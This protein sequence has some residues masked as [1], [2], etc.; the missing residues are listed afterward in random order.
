[1]ALLT[2]QK[3]NE[4]PKGAIDLTPLLW[5]DF[6]AAGYRTLFVEDAYIS[7]QV[8]N[9][10]NPDG[11]VSVPTDYYFRP[12]NVAMHGNCNLIDWRRREYRICTGPILEA[13]LILN[14]V[15]SV[16]SYSFFSFAYSPL[17]SKS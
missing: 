4:R 13:E 5:K 1:M 17:C 8:F 6:S 2:G 7:N 10:L 14:W 15:S 3:S 9:I 11:F 16:T 12:L